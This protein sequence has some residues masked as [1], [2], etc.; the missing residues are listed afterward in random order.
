MYEQ[1]FSNLNA[2]KVCGLAINV[3]WKVQNW[4]ATV[5]SKHPTQSK[6]GLETFKL[7]NLTKKKFTNLSLN[8]LLNNQI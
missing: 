1:A 4:V 6:K 5:H 7:H 3:S 2:C 8:K